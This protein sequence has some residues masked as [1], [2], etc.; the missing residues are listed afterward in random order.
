MCQKEDGFS[1]TVHIILT[2]GF[3]YFESFYFIL[4]YCKTFTFLNTHAI[5]IKERVLPS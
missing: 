2:V 5:N 4:L 3:V 1:S